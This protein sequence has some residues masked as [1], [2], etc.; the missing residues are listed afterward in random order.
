MKTMMTMMAV[1]LM[2][3]ATVTAQCPAK[4]QKKAEKKCGTTECA[5]ADKKADKKCDKCPCP[6]KASCTEAGSKKACCPKK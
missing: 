4:G 2:A 5:T 6:K 3:A 1:A